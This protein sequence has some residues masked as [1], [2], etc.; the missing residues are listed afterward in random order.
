[1]DE[2]SKALLK[3]DVFVQGLLL[4]WQKVLPSAS[5]SSGNNEAETCL[6][7]TNVIFALGLMQP[8]E[9]VI[10]VSSEGDIQVPILNQSSEALNFP[11]GLSIR[12]VKVLPTCE[13]SD[14]TPIK[15]PTAETG[16]YH[17]LEF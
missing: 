7:S 11:G 6:L 1:M 4:K 14:T 12:R 15:E 13:M 3:R 17:Q 9:F 16:P 10:K 2:S 5:T 8:A